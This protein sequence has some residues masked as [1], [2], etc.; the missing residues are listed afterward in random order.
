MLPAKVHQV[1]SIYFSSQ[2]HNGY[3]MV[4][5]ATEEKSS[6]YPSVDRHSKVIFLF[7]N[8]LVSRAYPAK[9]GLPAI[10]KERLSTLP[11]KTV[12]YILSHKLPYM[13]IH[14][15][16]VFFYT[17]NANTCSF[18]YYNNYIYLFAY[19]FILSHTCS[20]TCPFECRMAIH[21]HLFLGSPISRAY[22]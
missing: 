8:E 11:S 15:H 13:V 22:S 14:A 20:F 17:F 16:C 7:T 10:N 4:S 2:Y 5:H 12:S 18:L 6:S 21:V 9:D 1:H 3:R 19:A